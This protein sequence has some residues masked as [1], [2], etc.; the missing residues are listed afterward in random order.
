M[1]MKKLKSLEKQFLDQYPG[2]FNHPEMQ[3]I[4]KRHKMDKMIRMTQEYFAQGKFDDTEVLIQNLVKVVNASSM[5]S[6]FEKPKFRDFCKSLS[7]AEHRQLARS[8]EEQLH[9]CQHEGFE[10]MLSL[11]QDKKMAKWTL[12]SI[13]P[14]YF[15]PNEEV[16]IKPTTTKNIINHFGFKELQ[17]KATPSWDFYEAYRQRILDLKEQVDESLKPNNAAF[18]GFLMMSLD[19]VK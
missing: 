14:L 5:V 12:M 2:G 8:L 6:L 18:T 3:A 7:L 4:G 1:N 9:G 10:L 16:F 11:M 19:S 17:Y 13:V 15:K